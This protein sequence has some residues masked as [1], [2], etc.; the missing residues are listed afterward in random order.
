MFISRSKAVCPHCGQA[1]PSGMNSSMGRSYHASAPYFSNT[2][3]ARSTSAAEIIGSWHFTQSTA[4]IGTPQARCRETHQSGRLATMLCIRSWPH[5][6]IHF[7]SWSMAESAA[8]RS[9]W[10]LPSALC[11]LPFAMTGSPSS[12]M[13]H[14]AVARKITG[15]WQRQQCGY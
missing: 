3:A 13:N 5:A 14:C 4:G 2:D 11:P 10:P 12:V 15:L 6:G 1:K 8:A 9:V 7:T